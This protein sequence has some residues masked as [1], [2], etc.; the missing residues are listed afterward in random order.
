NLKPGLLRRKQHEFN[1]PNL[2]GHLPHKPIPC[3]KLPL[4]SPEM[5]CGWQG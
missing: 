5:G 3:F 4:R 2:G 1:S